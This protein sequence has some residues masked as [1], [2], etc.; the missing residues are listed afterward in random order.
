M[1]RLDTTENE[2]PF[3]PD[4]WSLEIG[5]VESS[6]LDSAPFH[7]GWIRVGISGYGYLWPW[8]FKDVV[9]RAQANHGMQALMDLCKQARPV[10]PEPADARTYERF[11]LGWDSPR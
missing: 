10:P 1:S 11:D 3:I 5:P 7:V 9:A 2:Q 8:T 6:S 4:S